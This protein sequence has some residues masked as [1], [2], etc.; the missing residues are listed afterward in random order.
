M[1]SNHFYFLVQISIF[2]V[3]CKSCYF[4]TCARLRLRVIVC[5][6]IIVFTL[7]DDWFDLVRSQEESNVSRKDE[8]EER[9]EEAQK[10]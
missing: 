5:L 3:I 8:L 1:A 10:Q 2:G 9:P 7:Y 4:G 6:N